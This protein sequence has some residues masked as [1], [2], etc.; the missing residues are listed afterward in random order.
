[1]E[2]RVCEFIDECNCS[3][4]GTLKNGGIAQFGYPIYSSHS[5]SSHCVHLCLNMLSLCLIS[6]TSVHIALSPCLI[7]LSLCLIVPILGPIAPI[8][9]R[10]S[11]LSIFPTL[12][13]C[14]S[15]MSHPPMLTS[16]PSLSSHSAG[17]CSFAQVGGRFCLTCR[18]TMMTF[19][20]NSSL[21]FDGKM[22]HVWGLSPSGSLR[23]P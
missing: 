10:I 21:C 1:M 17:K 19:Q 23:N 9:C 20:C 13:S 2:T 4:L 8:L 12:S 3:T 5:P 7:A 18:A 22:M 14:P 6:F 16:S 15:G 11:P